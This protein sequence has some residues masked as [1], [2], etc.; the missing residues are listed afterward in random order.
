MDRG[1][2]LGRGFWGAAVAPWQGRPGT[3]GGALLGMADHRSLARVHLVFPLAT[4]ALLG[5]SAAGHRGDERARG[6]IPGNRGSRAGAGPPNESYSSYGLP[7]SLVGAYCLAPGEPVRSCP[8]PKAVTQGGV[9]PPG[10]P[11]GCTSRFDVVEV[12]LRLSYI[13]VICQL[14]TVHAVFMI[15]TIMAPPTA[16]RHAPHLAQPPVTAAPAWRDPVNARR[17]GT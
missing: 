5:P 3:P 13:I 10:P 4:A 2:G 12:W 9:D 8:I 16:G 15:A 14:T 7:W 1:H 17:Y 6:T 11:P